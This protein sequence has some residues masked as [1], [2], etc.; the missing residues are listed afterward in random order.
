MMNELELFKKHEI[1]AKNIFEIKE[2]SLKE[3]RD[4]V[5]TYH[6]LGKSVF[7]AIY[8]Y[9]L[10]FNDDLVGVASYS[11]PQGNKTLQSWFNLPSNDK[12]VVELSRL[13]LIP[14]LNGTN[15]TSYL[16]S[17]SIKKLKFKGIRAVITLADSKR[18]VG[19]I[20]Q[21]C[22]FKYFG[23]TKEKNDF[24]S[25]NGDGTFKKGIRRVKISETEGVWVARSRKHR[26]A[27]LL[28]KHMFCNYEEEPYPKY[29][30]L[31]SFNCCDNTK[32]VFDN[33][34]KQLYTC[35]I[36]TNKLIKK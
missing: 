1:K 26:Y 3:A 16:L 27:F 11:I 7:M 32:T 13:C 8:N 5:Y 17:N 29:D 10:F 33:R 20:Y 25:Y 36:C 14:K 18:H 22:N 21:V 19:S 4:F 30:A 12:T 23:L 6:Y 9:G 15:A 28:D 34:N 2:V 31:V 24:Y 35:P